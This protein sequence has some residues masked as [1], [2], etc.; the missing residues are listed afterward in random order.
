MS[1]LSFHRTKHPE[2]H[3][4]FELHIGHCPIG[5][6]WPTTGLLAFLKNPVGR[7]IDME[8]EEM[9]KIC[10]QLIKNWPPYGVNRSMTQLELAIAFAGTR[11]KATAKWGVQPGVV[12]IR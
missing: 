3:K 1:L 5:I 2:P 6:Y 9:A 10:D 12:V 4:E 7:G 8:A 11:P